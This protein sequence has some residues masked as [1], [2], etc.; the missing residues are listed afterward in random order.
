MFFYLAYAVF[1]LAL[2]GNDIRAGE[3]K[4]QANP[5]SIDS[6]GVEQEY[7]S[8]FPVL[9]SSLEAD[10]GKKELQDNRLNRF[11]SKRDKRGYLKPP[12]L[13]YSNELT[14]KEREDSKRRMGHFVNK[15]MLT[16]F[17]EKY[18]IFERTWRKNGNDYEASNNLMD[19]GENEEA[20]I[21]DKLKTEVSYRLRTDRTEVE[22]KN[23]LF[24]VIGKAFYEG[25]QEVTVKKYFD[26]LGLETFY[27]LR[28]GQPTGE[29]FAIEKSLPFYLKAKTSY[30]KERPSQEDSPIS[31]AKVELLYHGNF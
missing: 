3:I 22:F 27:Y 9:L 21:A 7:E 16:A 1:A 25:R 20:S 12:Y 24:N 11:L 31:S 4:K 6:A 29:Q 30:G 18:G 13:P 28:P 5:P 8:F 15:W 14:A 10:A 2:F 19:S 17:N 26:G 23:D